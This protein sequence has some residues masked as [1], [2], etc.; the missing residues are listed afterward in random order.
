M[1]HRQSSHPFAWIFLAVATAF[2]ILPSLAI[3]ADEVVVVDA[4]VLAHDDIKCDAPTKAS[5]DRISFNYGWQFRTGLTAWAPAD[6]S[7]PTNVDPGLT[8]PESKIDYDAAKDNWKAVQLPH[9]GIIANAPSHDACPNGC[10]GRSFLPR[11][12]LWYRKT[13]NLPCGWTNE[14]HIWLEFEGSFRNTTVWINEQ[15][16]VIGHESGYTPFTIDL[17]PFLEKTKSAGSVRNSAAAT[18]QF[19]LAVFVDPDNGDD[20]GAS[21]GSGWW[22]EGGGLYRHVWLHRAP[23]QHRI[24][25]LFVYTNDIQL[26]TSEKALWATL[27]GNMTLLLEDIGEDSKRLKLEDYCVDI[28]IANN[29][30]SPLN[31]AE[32]SLLHSGPSDSLAGGFTN[33]SSYSYQYQVKLIFPHLWTTARPYLYHV[34][35]FLRDCFTGKE[36]DSVSTYHGI[37]TIDYT[38]AQGFSLN[39]QAFKIRG[40]CD[41]NTFGV[42]GA[43]MSNSLVEHEW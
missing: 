7:A 32:V 17:D 36:L 9:D 12:V 34:Q 6:E 19:T 21:R 10:S 8:P 22:Y 13:F 28:S 42:V 29:D 20:G 26:E 27:H 38:A 23:K 33:T 31:N 11:H 43:Y 14:N 16:V 37:R 24:D 39:S 3:A 1:N 25:D 30:G 35:V 18:P 2:L 40:F 41:H 5:R 4:D 15:P